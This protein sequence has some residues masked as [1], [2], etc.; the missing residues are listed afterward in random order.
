VIGI[1]ARFQ[2]GFA[3]FRAGMLI[4][5]AALVVVGQQVP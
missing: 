1:S 2:V 3:R 4:K 5:A